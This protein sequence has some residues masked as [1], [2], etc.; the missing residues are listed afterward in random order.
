M[1]ASMSMIAPSGTSNRIK[2]GEHMH[3]CPHL[4]LFC[5]PVMIRSTKYF[6][7]RGSPSEL[8][9]AIVCWMILFIQNS[10][11]VAVRKQYFH[12]APDR[13][14]TTYGAKQVGPCSRM[15]INDDVYS[16]INSDGISQSEHGSSQTC[17]KT[18][19][20]LTWRTPWDPATSGF[21]GL[22]FN[23][24]QWSTSRPPGGM[25]PK[26]Y[27]GNFLSESYS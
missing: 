14:G 16:C 17:K 25:P 24:K 15:C 22:R 1:V 13:A 4:Q 2:M 20:T 23:A 19:C 9:M 26:P 12:H 6:C 10:I 11:T 18:L 27:T 3:R 5:A 8:A 21:D 7:L